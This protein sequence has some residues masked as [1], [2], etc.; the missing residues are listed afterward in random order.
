[1][2][3]T[4]DHPE[5]LFMPIRVLNYDGVPTQKS[6]RQSFSLLPLDRRAASFRQTPLCNCAG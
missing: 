1:M 4:S 3:V 5:D 6:H 2:R